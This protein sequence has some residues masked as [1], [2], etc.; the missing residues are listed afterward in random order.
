MISKLAGLTINRFPEGEPAGY[1]TLCKGRF[2]ARNRISYL[3]EEPTSLNTLS[4]LPELAAA[5]VA[6]LKIEGR[7]RGRAYVAEVV[8]TF[9]RAIDGASA[10][11]EARLTTISEG[12][13]QTHGAYRKAWR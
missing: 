3:F 12:A 10:D 5:G 6:A 11:G 7:Q 9:R 8:S 2:V 4:L 1:P 13:R